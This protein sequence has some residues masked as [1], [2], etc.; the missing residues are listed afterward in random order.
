MS[1][2]DFAK[3]VLVTGASRGIGRAI[4]GKL[5]DEG[6]TVTGTRSRSPMPAEL[7]DHTRFTSVKV[8]FTRVESVNEMLA[9]LLRSDQ[10][11]GVLI[12]NAGIAD[13]Y[14]LLGE[15]SGWIEHTSRTMLVNYTIPAMLTRW[16]LPVWIRRQNGVLINI[17]SRAAYR[18]DTG[19]FADYAASKAALTAFTKSVA[20]E[21][22]RHRIAAVTIAPGF[23]ETDMARDAI[24]LYG[25]EHVMKGLA[26]PELT[27]PSDVAE[28]VAA[29]A[30]GRMLHITGTTIHVNG[31][32][33][34]V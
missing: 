14:D 3:Q 25:K 8:D 2:E 33:Y 4:A 28:V 19:D 16:V 29:V 18:G 15:D 30:S 6:Y 7:Q 22:S 32:S 24:R 1:K 31:G 12:N 23:I 5:L 13:G 9:P 11:P 26:V 20:R 10:A 21:Y 27:Q 34:M 17:A